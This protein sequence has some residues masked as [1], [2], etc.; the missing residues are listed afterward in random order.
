MI[1][2]FFV[3]PFAFAL[4]AASAALAAPP[5]PKEIII[6]ANDQMKFSV[7]RIEATPGQAIHV[8]LRNEGTLPKEVMGHNWILLKAGRDGA[9]YVTAALP[10]V[11]DDY[12]PKAFADQVLA[13]I[14]LLGARHEGDVTFNAPEIPG[15][16][17]FLCSFPAHFQAGMHGELIVK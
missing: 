6:V 11:K 7:T 12:Q 17:V 15:T 5:P 3:R 4:F 10:A 14:P 8:H 1:P 2:K 9:A 16:Y 13:A